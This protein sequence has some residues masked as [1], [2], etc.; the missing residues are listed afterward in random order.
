M[1]DK[2]YYKTHHYINGKWEEDLQD[3]PKDYDLAIFICNKSEADI[4]KN[5]VSNSIIKNINDDNIRSV[6]EDCNNYKYTSLNRFELDIT[7]MTL[8]KNNIAIVI[9][10]KELYVFVDDKLIDWIN[11]VV[12]MFKQD[13]KFKQEKRVLGS[14]FLYHF[15]FALMSDFISML[16]YLIMELII[17]IL[18]KQ[19]KY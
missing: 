3:P 12:D 10:E 19:I 4:L 1:G 11:R 7:S 8:N 6:F 16:K 5:K 2:R 18:K 13:D 9:F 14:V 17:T 15:I